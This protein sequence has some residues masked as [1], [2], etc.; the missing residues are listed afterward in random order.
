LQQNIAIISPDFVFVLT[1]E[2][3]HRLCL[4]LLKNDLQ[5]VDYKEIIITSG[6]KN[7]DLK[8]L[9]EI[10]NFLSDGGATRQSLLINVGGGVVTDIGG[11]AAATFKRGIRFLNVPTTLLAA[12]D[13]AFGGK[14]G[15][16]FNGLKNEIGTFALPE[17]TIINVD[18]FKTLDTKN[19]LSGFAEM[20]KHSLLSGYDLFNET[21]K[22]DLE[23]FDFAELEIILQKNI[24][25]KQSIT[26][27]DF[28]ECGIRKI[29]NFGHTF[30][31]AFESLLADTEMP[32]LHG[33][34][35]GWG[36]VCELYLS[37]IK[38]NFP[39][40]ILFKINHLVK[41]IYG[42]P[43][44]SCRNYDTLYNIMMHDKKNI[45]QQINFV[46]LADVG[47]PQIGQNS[48]KEEI[49][50]CFDFLHEN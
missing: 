45:A 29:L 1:D 12:A 25:F 43:D 16:N 48:T 36:I 21:L 23:K 5:N 17:A 46:L 39:K 32:V 14:T 9:C 47:Q 24:Q 13:A 34:A 22:F 41:K 3:T 6:E 2:N 31:H 15:I 7:K 8:S 30:A 38:L 40:D 33:Y 50:E 27:H 20:I 10:W 37:F 42:K 28:K 11:F 44:F 49:L 26:N 4:P 19:L 18:F 35:V